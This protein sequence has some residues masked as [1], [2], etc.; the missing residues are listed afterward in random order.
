MKNKIPFSILPFKVLSKLSQIFFG[1]AN[2]IEKNIPSLKLYLEQAEMT[3]L[4]D[5]YMA[6]CITS[7]IINFIFINIFLIIILFITDIGNSILLSI[8]ISIPVTLFLFFQ[9]T[10]F[11]KLKANK[12]IKDIEKNLLPTLQDMMVQLNSGIPL[13]TILVNISNQNYGEVS[14]E[15]EKAVKK[16]SAGIPQIEVLDE[17][18]SKNPSL[19]FRRTIWQLVNGLKTGSD[20][21]I[22]I[23]EIISALS[24]E[25]LLQIQKYGGQL[26]PLAMFYML[27][28]VILPSLGMTFLVLISSFISPSAFFAKTI[29]WSLYGFVLFFQIIFI[30]IIKT[31][32]PTLLEG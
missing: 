31:K 28:T 13:F 25:Q 21:A 18:A 27:I 22:V 17:I 6:I 19:Y 7:S 24:E 16:I 8:I 3:V 1:L 9:Q 10:L 2:K 23:K 5:A 4:P 11:P 26:N 32:R 29:F 12:K 14:K 20:T 30:G 15:F